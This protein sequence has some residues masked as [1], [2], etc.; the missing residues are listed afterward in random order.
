[1]K[2][3]FTYFQ[4]S[5]FVSVIDECRY[6]FSFSAEL[7]LIMTFQRACHFAVV[8][9]WYYTTVQ[10]TEFTTQEFRYNV[11]LSIAVFDDTVVDLFRQ[12]WRRPVRC[13]PPHAA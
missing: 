9:L 3:I 7:F 12:T 2:T 6:Y 5:I 11:L 1:M 10:L 13:Y 4:F 8:V